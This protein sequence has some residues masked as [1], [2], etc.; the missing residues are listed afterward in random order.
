MRIPLSMTLATGASSGSVDLPR[1][2]GIE[3]AVSERF[4]RLSEF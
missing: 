3:P 4:R 1:T 2:T